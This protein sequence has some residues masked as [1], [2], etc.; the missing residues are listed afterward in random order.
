M[1]DSRKQVDGSPD[2]AQPADD[3]PPPKRRT[4]RIE[5][6]EIPRSESELLAGRYRIDALLGEGTTGKVYVAEHVMMEKRV[7]IKI[8]RR[9]MQNDRE[10]VARFRREARSAASL[11][12]PNICQATDFGQTDAGALFLV[13]EYLDGKTLDELVADGTR[14]PPEDALELARQINAGLD[15]AH[16]QGIV[17]RDLKPENV[18]LV[19]DADGRRRAKLLDFGI[20]HLATPA[21]S[22]DEQPRLTREG[23]AY[24]TPH[25]MSPE[26][27]AGREID[28]RTDLYALGA[29]LFEM[30]TGTPP[31]RADKLSAV[32]MAHIDEPI[33]QLDD[34]VSETTFS[35]DL[36]NLI[37]RLMAKD[38]DERPDSAGE[39]DALLSETD[40]D[41]SSVQRRAD[42]I[43]RTLSDGAGKMAERFGPVAG[44]V[45]DGASGG[46]ATVRTYGSEAREI[47]GEIWNDF[48]PRKRW[49]VIGI[50][51]AWLATLVIAGLLFVLVSGPGDPGAD[52]L[53]DHHTTLLE[54][55]VVADALA[56][57]A[58]G[59]QTDLERLLDDRSDDPHLRYLALETDPSPDAASDVV[60]E[61]GF[62]FEADERYRHHP[63]LIEILTDQLGDDHAAAELLTN[64]M[65][66]TIR[67]ILARRA[68]ID[69]N[70]SRRNLAYELLDE[71]DQFD[72]LEPWERVAA[73]MR[74]TS[75]CSELGAKIETLVDIGDPAAIPT[76]EIYRDTP[77]T[78]CGNMGRS[79]CLACIRDDLAEALETLDGS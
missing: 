79:D 22:D 18:A 41:L 66:P 33:P 8:L 75:G 35:D 77:K 21:D 58:D 63:D 54:D 25:Y 29:V 2:G 57:A 24:G 72:E 61:V 4:R 23:L 70:T 27:V 19:D 71:H 55:D 49:F 37:D 20:A 53:G 32:M 3:G 51:G 74:Q 13:M 62:L 46:I 40:T 38:A 7:A 73:E 68:R 47:A 59:D 52:A 9:E 11:D 28:H 30:L 67:Q 50:A 15:A 10:I 39:V 60:D 31:Y 64:H 76:L 5:D 34:R 69:L 36:Q 78:G 16:Q 14:L 12:H 43:E 48:S 17:H 45:I 44:R 26:Q 42:A 56:D 6:R 1:S 65:N